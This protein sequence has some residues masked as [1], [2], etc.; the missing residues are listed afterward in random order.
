MRQLRQKT[1]LSFFGLILLLFSSF[2]LKTAAVLGQKSSSEDS[3]NVEKAHQEIWRRFIDEHAILIDFADF[4]GRFDRP[5]AAEFRENKPNA[6]GWWTPTEN[7][8]MF[9]GL[10]LDGICQRW[11]H[12]R[13]EADR[14]KAKRL[15]Q[16]LL[17]LA[18]I[19]DTPGFIGRGVAT[20]G[21][22][23]PAMGSN[24][25]TS[26]WFYGLWRYLDTGMPDPPER[27][28]II[29]KMTEVANALLA[30]NWR[31]P[32]M[33][34][35][36]SKYRNSFATFNWEG[37]PRLLF[38][39]KALHQL[40]GDAKWNQLYQ[41]A[42]REMGGEP[43][44]SRLQICAEGMK[45]DIPKQFRWTGVSSTVDVRALWEMEKDPEMRKAYEEGLN[46]S[47]RS[48][49]SGISLWHQFDRNDQ[50]TFLH[51]WRTLNQWW[52]PQHSEQDA[53]DVSQTELNELVKLSPRRNQ[54]LGFVREPLWMAWIVTMAPDR[55]LVE[56]HRSE[57][58]GALTHFRADKLYYSQFF[59][60]EAVWF[61][62][63]NK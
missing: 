57:I 61:R 17:F 23:P 30:N 5:T 54:E 49:A 22:T 12:R 45:F 62:L 63:Q 59:P 18:S 20:D 4:D 46:A 41:D 33:S 39:L 31:L 27:R 21:K 8:S 2:Q 29:A 43:R 1:A 13:N 26:P 11:M 19:G 53:L 16:G 15:A 47:A 25:Q 35:S 9:N 58:R 44:R 52:K 50:K 10:Y 51:D 24:D 6:L 37:A 14:Q 60:A 38:I 48:A 34:Y 32:T 42:A 55:K 56:Q 3:L 36:P 40:T 7:G 28:Q